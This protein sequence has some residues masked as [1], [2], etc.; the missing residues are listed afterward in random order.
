MLKDEYSKSQLKVGNF[1]IRNKSLNLFE[2]EVFMKTLPKVAVVLMVLLLGTVNL[3]AP[4]LLIHSGQGHMEGQVVMEGVQFSKLLM[5]DI[6]LWERH[7]PL[8]QVIVM[9]IS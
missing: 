5:V 7:G 6:L 4:R 8:V 9:S 3:F 2:K 1:S